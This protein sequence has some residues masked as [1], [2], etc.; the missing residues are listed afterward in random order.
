MFPDIASWPKPQWHRLDQFPF[1]GIVSVHFEKWTAAYYPSF[2]L[3]SVLGFI[4]T[5][6]ALDI[7]TLATVGKYFIPGW[8][9]LARAMYSLV[10]RALWQ[11]WLAQ[12]VQQRW[13]AT[14]HNNAPAK[15]LLSAKSPTLSFALWTYAPIFFLAF[16]S[17]MYSWTYPPLRMAFFWISLTLFAEPLVC[18]GFTT[19]MDLRQRLEAS[20]QTDPFPFRSVVALLLCTT[21]AVPCIALMVKDLLFTGPWEME[22][23][24]LRV[25][26]ISLLW[27]FTSVFGCGFWAT[28]LLS[29]LYLNYN[30]KIPSSGRLASV[31]FGAE[32]GKAD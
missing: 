27:F 20:D 14:F 21:G 23:L 3:T 13:A 19:I 10:E 25:F 32:K 1:V 24:E 2:V 31:G 29:V 30:G 6:Y 18:L 8:W 15:A 11:R 5:A 26:E 9:L 16:G 22:G 17:L 7:D 28:G 4:P 12:C